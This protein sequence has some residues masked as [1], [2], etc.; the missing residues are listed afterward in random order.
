MAS[1]KALWL[2]TVGLTAAAQNPT[3]EPRPDLTQLTLEQLLRIEVT[4]VARKEQKLSRAPAAIFVIRQEDIRRSGLTN[5][6]EILRLAPG[7]H[8]AQIDGN[9][10]AITARGFNGQFAGKMLVLIDGRSVYTPLFSGVYWEMHDL[11]PEDIERIEVIR[12]P[13]ATMWGAN[14]VNGV[15]NI[16]TKHAKDTK[17]GLATVG[18][19]NVEH[20]SGG[21]RY[22]AELRP[23]LYYRMHTRHS[24][25]DDLRTADGQAAADGWESSRSGM[26]LD[27]ERSETESLMVQADLYNGRLRQVA[28]LPDLSPPYMRLQ[29]QRF[30]SVSGDVLARWRRQQPNGTTTTLQAFWDRY[31]RQEPIFGER[32]DTLDFELERRSTLRFRQELTWGLGY[33]HTTDSSGTSPHFSLVPTHRR[34]QLFSAFVQDEFELV[35]SKLMLTLGS[36]VERNDF[37]GFELQPTVRLLWEPVPTHSFWGAVSRAVRTPSRG[38]S[39]GTS[40]VTTIPAS[41]QSQGLPVAFLFSGNAG[42][43]PQTLLAWEAGYRVQPASRVSFDLTGFHMIYRNLRTLTP[44]VPGFERAPVPHLQ[45]AAALGNNAQGVTSGAEA[46]AQWNAA[47]FWK[48]TGTYSWLRLRLRGSNVG[49]APTTI[50]ETSQIAP[51]QGSLRSAIDLPRNF[52]LDGGLYVI[53][54]L[55]G[56]APSTFSYPEV[57]AVVRFDVRLGWRPTKNLELSVTG[58]NL[59]DDQHPEFNPEVLTRRSEV[60]R[61]LHGGLTWRF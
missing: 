36:K 11:M 27:W 23:N 25:R 20:G 26:R 53:D 47:R 17:G 55:R 42:F 40:W 52:Q 8:V 35:P 50:G 30:D 19:G 12:G 13:G 59:L 38:E 31:D 34:L 6:P 10:W 24:R 28:S 2:V 57:P 18:G 5:V 56:T 58:Q 7:L 48:L 61:G 41:P 4:S 60:R 33:R 39:D 3:V 49:P 29:Q 16:Y 14:A 45:L 1:K 15:I 9:K 54:T 51:H 46:V 22:G 21:F 32:R 37:S 44:G 43:Q